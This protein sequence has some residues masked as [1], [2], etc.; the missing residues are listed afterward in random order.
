MILWYPR[1]LSY[2]RACAHTGGHWRTVLGELEQRESRL[3][4]NGGGKKKLGAKR[5]H[6]LGKIMSP[7]ISWL[8]VSLVRGGRYEITGIKGRVSRRPER[9]IL[10]L[11]A[12][13]S[14]LF[15]AALATLSSCVFWREFFLLFPAGPLSFYFCLSSLCLTCFRA[16]LC[17]CRWICA[18]GI[19]RTRRKWNIKLEERD[20]RAVMT[21][22]VFRGRGVFFECTE[23]FLGWM[24]C[25]YLRCNTGNICGTCILERFDDVL[26]FSHISMPWRYNSCMTILLTL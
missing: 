19:A 5:V 7:P 24:D 11:V 4:A 12:S 1:S 16:R 14:L 18:G 26:H 20:L 17:C 2:R 25:L 8:V 23:H 15:F 13:S 21:E 22:S 9:K 6:H 10:C 3:W